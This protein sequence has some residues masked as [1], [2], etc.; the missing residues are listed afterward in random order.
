MLGERNNSLVCF[1]VRKEWIKAAASFALALST[2]FL[3]L[4]DFL[5]DFGVTNIFRLGSLANT[6]GK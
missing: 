3:F 4:V 2:S 1:R 6:G 5:V